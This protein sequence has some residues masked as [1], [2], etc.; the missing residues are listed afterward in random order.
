MMNIRYKNELIL[1]ASII[2]VLSSYIFKYK[3]FESSQTLLHTSQKDMV[4]LQEVMSLQNIW[5]P[6]KVSKQLEG[7][8]HIVS[9]NQIQWIKRG[10]KLSV[11]FK[12]I[13]SNQL[14]KILNKILNIAIQIENISIIKKQNKYTMELKCKY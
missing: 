11:K 14:N 9:P 13:D 8:K 1:L 3:S 4:Q 7:L 2:F 6:K 10:K 12:D 5:S